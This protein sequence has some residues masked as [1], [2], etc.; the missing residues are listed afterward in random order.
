M[1]SVCPADI[2]VSPLPPI[3][4]LILSEPA[5]KSEEGGEVHQRWQKEC[6]CVWGGSHNVTV[7]LRKAV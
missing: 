1:P 7:E 6:V 2:T 5:V 4:S 3:T